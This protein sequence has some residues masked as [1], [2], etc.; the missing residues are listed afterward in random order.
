VIVTCEECQKTYDDA[1][2]FTFCP[3]DPFMDPVDLERKKR[4]IQIFDTR[5][6]YKVKDSER[7]GTI[8]SVDYKGFVSLSG[9]SIY[10][11]YDPMSLEETE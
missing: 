3:H 10:E 7:K 5:K 6:T 2:C 9:G 11:V 8:T 4:A 1:E